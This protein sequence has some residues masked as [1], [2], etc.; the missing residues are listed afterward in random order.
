MAH[1]GQP[2]LHRRNFGQLG[3][4]GLQAM[5]TTLIALQGGAVAK[6]TNHGAT[7]YRTD[8]LRADGR[9]LESAWHYAYAWAKAW[10]L[11]FNAHYE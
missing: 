8:I 6:I 1:A 5:K 10:A 11:G 4:K 9:L 3:P 7:R 2:L